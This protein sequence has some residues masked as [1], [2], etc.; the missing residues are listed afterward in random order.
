MGNLLGELTFTPAP[1]FRL[2]VVAT[3]FWNPSVLLIKPVSLPQ[4]MQVLLPGGFRTGNGYHSWGVRGD[5]TF[6]AFV[7]ASSI[8]GVLTYARS[9]FESAE[10]TNPLQPAISLEGY[11]I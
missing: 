7:P 2:S 1:F 9:L 5:F 3:P 6:S 4:G 11:H 8:N 10:Y